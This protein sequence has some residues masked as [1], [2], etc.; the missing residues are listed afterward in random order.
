MSLDFKNSIHMLLSYPMYNVITLRNLSM[1]LRTFNT[2]RATGT[3]EIIK[4][5][6]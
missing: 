5:R 2:R 1:L 6:I 4:A 3:T